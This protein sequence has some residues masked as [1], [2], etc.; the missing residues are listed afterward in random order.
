[1]ALRWQDIDLGTG[2]IR[3]ERSW[4]M[5]EGVIEPKSAVGR[6]TSRL[7]G[8]SEITWSSTA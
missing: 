4:D 3:V 7:P 5:K 8:C 6:R 1:M 2:V